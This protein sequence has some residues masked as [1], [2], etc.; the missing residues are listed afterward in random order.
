MNKNCED[1]PRCGQILCPFSCIEASMQCTSFLPGC[2]SSR[3]LNASANGGAWPLYDNDITLMNGHSYNL[4]LPP[5]TKDQFGV[6]DKE[7]LRQMMLKH[8]SIFRDQVHE[9]HRL[10]RR[11]QELMD[12]IKRRELSTHNNRLQTSHSSSFLFKIS[13]EAAQRTW[14]TASLPWV[15]PAANRLP[16]LS[17]ENFLSTSSFPVRRNVQAGPNTAQTE[18]SLKDCKLLQSNCEKPRKKMLDLELPAEEYIDSEEEN[19]FGEGKVSEVPAVPFYPP[20]RMIEVSEKSHLKLFHCGDQ[21]GFSSLDSLSR[22]TNDLADLN[23]PIRLES[24]PCFNVP[25]PFSKSTN[26]SPASPPVNGNKFHCS[27]DFR[28]SPGVGN[29]CQSGNSFCVSSQSDSRMEDCLSLIGF[30]HPKRSSDRNMNFGIMDLNMPPSCVLDS[31]VSEQ[32]VR[33]QN[34]V[35]KLEDSRAMLSGSTAKPDCS[36]K[37]DKEREDLS[38][39]DLGFS[40]AFPTS[41]C[42]VEPKRFKTTDESE[43]ID[44]KSNEKATRGSY[45]VLD[46]G[47]HCTTKDQSLDVV[48][49][50]KLSWARNQIDLNS[51]IDDVDE[52]SPMFSIPKVLIETVTEI[53]LEAPVS[54]ENK[55]SSPPRGES[56]ENQLETPIRLSKPMDRDTNDDELAFKTAAEAIVLISTPGFQKPLIKNTVCEASEVSLGDS[57]HWFAGVV[58]SVADDHENEDSDDRHELLSDVSD[59]FEAMTLELTETIVEDYRC[60]NNGQNEEETGANLLPSQPRRGRAR[61][62]RQRKDFQSEILPSLASLSR[63]EVTEDLQMIGGLMEA[64]GFPVGTC[65]GRRNSGR[66]GCSRSRRRSSNSICPVL[67]PENN[68]SELGFGEKSLQGWGKMNRRRRGPRIP[69]SN[70]RLI[71]V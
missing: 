5:P 4:F 57:L 1:R 17:S 12:E 48:V 45:H 24:L 30:N 14:Q 66:N 62:V 15:N 42:D 51:C 10:Y 21:G 28:S 69:A 13:S 22:R 23:E 9:L 68:E 54:P 58:S 20:K 53:D 64:A 39:T 32:N 52:S 63:H 3:D 41:V 19:E 34:G 6:S 50:S 56:E 16:V 27:G 35:K 71:F 18:H 60:K 43:N 44:I 11:Q 31:E 70:R 25:V 65:L 8:E 37:P 29:V 40:Q 36:N 38:Q 46:S 55:E 33:T 49:D 2:Y 59:Y 47:K 61:R 67:K 26:S 7:V